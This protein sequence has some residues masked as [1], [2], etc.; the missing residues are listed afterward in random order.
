MAPLANQALKSAPLQSMSNC[1][2]PPL[3]LIAVALA[4]SA[5]SKS[6]LGV[7]AA[8]VS[9]MSSIPVKVAPAAVYSPEVMESAPDEASTKATE[10][11]VGSVAPAV[12]V[13]VTLTSAPEMSSANARPVWTSWAS[14]ARAT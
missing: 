6:A 8:N 14:E 4:G 10:A 3:L 5:A 13:Q 9:E 7:P 1:L 11:A 2:V 12:P